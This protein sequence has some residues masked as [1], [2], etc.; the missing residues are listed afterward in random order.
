M[1]DY[2]KK[3]RW[4]A[5]AVG[6]LMGVLGWFIFYTGHHLGTTLAVQKFTGIVVGIFS[7]KHVMD[8]QYYMKSFKTS[9]IEWQQVFVIFLFFGSLVASKLSKKKRVEYVPV[10]WAQNFGKSK[11]KRNIYAFIGGVILIFGARL[12]GGCTS[13]HAISGGLQLSV[14]S[15]IF[16]I[17]VFAFAIPTALIIYRKSIK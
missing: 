10:I 15:W 1:I 12:A 6:A 9:V 7:K 3:D 8:S 2:L 5:Y 11:L 14:I 4:S 16:M 13:G 17:V